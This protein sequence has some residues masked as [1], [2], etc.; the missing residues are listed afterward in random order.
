ML[1][2]A[3]VAWCWVLAEAWL[4]ARNLEI[5]LHGAL[6]LAAALTLLLLTVQCKALLTPIP[7]LCRSSTC[8]RES[9]S[10]SRAME[11][12]A[13][14]LIDPVTDWKQVIEAA[15]SLGHSVV[16][17]QLPAE[18]LPEKFQSFLPTAP[19]LREAGVDHVLSV[20]QRDV[21]SIT[22]QLQIIA[23]DYNLKFMGVIPLS[24]IAV[25]V[26]DC[27]ASCL[28]LPHNQLDLL[29]ARRD[30]GM[31]KNA[32]ESAG[33]RIAKYKRVASMQDVN[34][35]MSQLS[36][37]YPIVLKTPAG[38]STTD[39]FICSNDQEAERAITSIL[40]KIS[41]DGRRVEK[42]LLEEYIGGV[43]FAINLMAFSSLDNNAPP[44]L[45][46]TDMWKYEKTKRAR[47]AH[48]EICS[49]GDYPSLIEYA[50]NVARAVG[51][52]VGA[53]HVE[54]KAEEVNNGSFAHPVLIEVG[55]RLS[56]GRKSIMAQSAIQ[57]WNPFEAL[58][59][60]HS[61]DACEISSQNT[62]F[63]TP[64]KF[65]RHIFLPI[66]QKGIVEKIE[67][68]VSSLST[69]HSLAMICKAGDVVDETTDIVTCAGFVWLVGDRKQVDDDTDAVMSSF[70]LSVTDHEE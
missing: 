30:K 47:Y 70:V 16:A 14:V 51:V 52:R 48:A 3:I 11:S 58:V 29:T 12:T 26:S 50:T 35:A 18:A 61:M 24:E 46:V 10:T 4:E 45:L 43:E 5:I 41:P 8:L 7:T 39:V 65:A 49:P 1:L 64:D 27:V 23:S 57:N 42:A 37:C 62:N 56:G 60:S 25:E 36:L 53:A 69:L 9:S 59:Q 13:V 44:R 34:D 17:V 22:Q 68:D 28:G 55:A 40:G 33:L 67:I 32:V 54:L 21:F 2:L 66:E 63:L 31:M 20:E 38:M 6:M 19:A 15:A